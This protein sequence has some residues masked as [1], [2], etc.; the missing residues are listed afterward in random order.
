MGGDLDY[1]RNWGVINIYGHDREGANHRNAYTKELLELEL[2][3]A[4]FKNIECY[5]TET[6]PCTKMNNCFE[7]RID[8]DIKAIEIK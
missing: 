8:G 6:R 3:E 7:Y 4:G 2:R 5:V 1:K